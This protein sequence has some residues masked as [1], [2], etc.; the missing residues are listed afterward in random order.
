MQYLQSYCILRSRMGRDPTVARLICLDTPP[1]VSAF[2]IYF[3]GIRV[4]NLLI[5]K[6][7]GENLIRLVESISDRTKLLLK[8]QL[9]PVAVEFEFDDDSGIFRVIATSSPIAHCRH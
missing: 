6:I 9:V 1:H 8:L 3:H 5:V 7:R 2:R 4:S